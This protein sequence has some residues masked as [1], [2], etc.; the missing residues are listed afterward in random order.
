MYDF[1]GLVAVCLGFHVLLYD[2]SPAPT[3]NICPCT[4]VYDA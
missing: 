2:I 1:K 3:T 4:P